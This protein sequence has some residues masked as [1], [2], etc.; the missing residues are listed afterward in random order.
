MLLRLLRPTSVLPPTEG[1]TSGVS[2]VVIAARERAFR[3]S[4]D[5]T[6]ARAWTL[7]DRFRIGCVQIVRALRKWYLSVC[8]ASHPQQQS[9]S[10]MKG[11][12]AGCS[13]HASQR[14]ALRS[15]LS[16]HAPCVSRVSRSLR[17]SG[18]IIEQATTEDRKGRSDE[19][20]TLRAM[21]CKRTREARLVAGG[22]WNQMRDC[23]GAQPDAFCDVAVAQV[24]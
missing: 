23:A 4:T 22:D 3:D 18:A 20:L 19:A 7:S 5:S 11:T 10:D 6:T 8:V 24:M 15:S 21:S 16:P 1:F 9:G 13:P 12:S 17:D 2:A 14:I